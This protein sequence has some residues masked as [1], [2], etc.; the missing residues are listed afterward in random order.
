MEQQT[1]D[2]RTEMEKAIDDEKVKNYQDTQVEEP[3]IIP[4]DEKEKAALMD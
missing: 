1:L 4:L 2:V 3:F